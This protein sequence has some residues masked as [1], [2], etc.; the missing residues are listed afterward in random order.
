MNSINSWD[1]VYFVTPFGVILTHLCI[2]TLFFGDFALIFR[3][4]S[5]LFIFLACFDFIF[6]AIITKIGF[7]S[8]ETNLANKMISL[9]RHF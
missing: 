8:F 2:K 4:E 6:I 3:N 9:P 5:M 7:C 1:C